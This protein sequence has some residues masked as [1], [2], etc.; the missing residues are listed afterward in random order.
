MPFLLWVPRWL[1]TPL[2]QLPSTL[3]A[4]H[5]PQLCLSLDPELQ[6]LLQLLESDTGFLSLTTGSLVSLP[7]NTTFISC[8]TAAKIILVINWLYIY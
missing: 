1:L 3:C 4:E 7:L 2:G 8:H 6:S 5:L